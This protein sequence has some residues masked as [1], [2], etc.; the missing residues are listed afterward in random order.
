M[1]TCVLISYKNSVNCLFTLTCFLF[2]MEG[3]ALFLVALHISIYLPSLIQLDC[4]SVAHWDVV[5]T[6]SGR[7]RDVVITRLVQF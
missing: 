2:L 6:L 1:P 4:P 7:C 3:V 5:G